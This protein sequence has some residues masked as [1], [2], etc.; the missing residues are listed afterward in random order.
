MPNFD[1]VPLPA[2]DY[3]AGTILL[4]FWAAAAA[5]ALLLLLLFLAAFRAGFGDAVGSIFRV[6]LIAVIAVVAWT[7]INRFAER[8]RADE[9]RAL[10]Q[11][12]A[13]LTARA[14]APGSTLG[15]LEAGLGEAVEGGCEKALFASP[16]TVGAAVNYVAARWSLLVDGIDFAGRKDP[17]Y[18]AAIEGVRRALESDR[19]GFVAQMLTVREGCTALKCEAMSALRDANRVRANLGERTFDGLV[20]R[21]AAGWSA[22]SRPGGAPVAAMPGSAPTVGLNFP[23]ASSIPPVSIMSSEPPAPAAPPAAAPGPANPPT[24]GAIAPRRAPAKPRPPQTAAPVPLGPPPAA[25]AAP[26]PR[27]Q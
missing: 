22:R 7:F 3:A 10:D 9:R 11:R 6:A 12:L 13:D 4:P 21:N 8:D 15:C 17:S 18:E 19:F 14:L 26:Q 25:A 27:A 16:E 1:N 20:A 24:T 2:V 23:S 5:A